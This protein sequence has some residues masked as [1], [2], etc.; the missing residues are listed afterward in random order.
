MAGKFDG[1]NFNIIVRPA[2]QLQIYLKRI[3]S[4]FIG[5]TH[6]QIPVCRRVNDK[7]I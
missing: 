4:T 7:C 2:A 6:K 1:D 5:N 3:R